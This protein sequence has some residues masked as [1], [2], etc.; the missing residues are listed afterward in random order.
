MLRINRQT[1]YAVR[2][3]LA[4]AKR[5]PEARLSTAEIRTEMLI[6]KSVS[7][8]VVADLARGGFI[9]TFPGRDG[10]ISLARPAAEIN[11]LQ[12]T[13]HFESNF[14]ISECIH[15]KG[16]CPFEEKC[17]VRLRWARLQNIIMKELESITFAELRED[18]F[19]LQNLLK[20]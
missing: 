14:A 5:S 11:L 1:D 15:A 7:L 18:A 10:G 20:A 3:L 4:L 9:Q 8:R 19:A 13:E 16:V 12:V 17:P 2:V 6:P